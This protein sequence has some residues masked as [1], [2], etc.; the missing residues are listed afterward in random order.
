MWIRVQVFV[1]RSSFS[2]MT[3]PTIVHFDSSSAGMRRIGELLYRDDIIQKNLTLCMR[4]RTINHTHPKKFP[5]NQ[6]PLPSPP[7]FSPQIK[8]YQ[9]KPKNQF[10]TIQTRFELAISTRPESAFSFREGEAGKWRLT[11]RP[12]NPF[13]LSSSKERRDFLVDPCAD[14]THNLHHTRG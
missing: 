6:P 8:R 1:S 3:V 14:R 12:L 2:L 5:I 9:S 7:Q 10:P 11:I 4:L 13:P